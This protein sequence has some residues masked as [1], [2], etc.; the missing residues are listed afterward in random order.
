M[1]LSN[2]IVILA[3]NGH[4]LADHSSVV[5]L[6]DLKLLS[7]KK[8]HSV[9][10]YL[11]VDLIGHIVSRRVLLT[12]VG[13][14]TCTVESR[15]LDEL[16][17]LAEILFGLSGEANDK[18]CPYNDVGDLSAEL[19]HNLSD[20]LT[21]A[22]AV[23]CLEH[24]IADV[25]KGKVDIFKYS[26]IVTDLGNELVG[27][28]VGIAIGES[29]PR[30]GGRLGDPAEKLCKLI[31]S[32]KIKTVSG[33]I[34]G[35]YAKLTDAQR[36][37]LLCLSNNVLESAATEL[38]SDR[39]DSA[40]GASVVTALG[41]LEIR[42]IFGSCEYSVSAKANGLLVLKGGVFPLRALFLFYRY[43]FNSLNDV[44]YA[45]NAENGIDLGKLLKNAFTVSLGETARNDYRL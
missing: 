18:G 6:I 17:E 19:C 41:D 16:T 30:N 22:V 27:H 43:R 28:L 35:N 31:L 4:G 5:F 15:F 23:H 11:L 7:H 8:I 1:Y 44:V 40:V 9:K 37:K 24:M 3:E 36:L 25:L 33:Y 38:T 10:L 42:H 20:G 13:E 34:L 14:H 39:G 29:Y 32:V 45:S 2:G 26:R 12:G 21:V